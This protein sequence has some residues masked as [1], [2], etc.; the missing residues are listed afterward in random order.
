MFNVNY[1]QLFILFVI[2]D[3][4]SSIIFERLTEKATDYKPCFALSP[5][6]F[7]NATKLINSSSFV[8]SGASKSNQNR[9]VF[10]PH[11]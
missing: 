7:K 6:F 3:F 1:Y 9:L 2:N 11:P 10:F 5:R 8:V 4:I